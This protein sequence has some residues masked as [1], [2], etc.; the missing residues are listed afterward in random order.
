MALD[1]FNFSIRLNA[2]T[3]N[4]D[5]QIA[6]EQNVSYLRFNLPFIEGLERQLYDLRVRL[7]A[8]TTRHDTVVIIDVD[9]PSLLAEG[10][11]PWPRAKIAQLVDAL[12]NDYGISTMGFDVLFAEPEN[13]Y[14]LDEVKT[15]LANNGATIDT[16]QGISGDARLAQ[17][18][19]DRSIVLGIVFEPGGEDVAQ[20][21]GVLP[22]P[23]FAF[24][25]IPLETILSE[26]RAPLTARYSA[27]IPIL[28]DSAETAG[29]FS[30]SE[31]DSDGI[32]RRVE[33]LT[34]YDG[35]LYGSM[36]LKLI[37]SFFQ[38]LPEPV[39]VGTTDD[40]YPGLEAISM[41]L[42]ENPLGV[43][44]NASV[45]VPYAKRGA[46][47]EYVSATEILQ[48]TYEG[49]LAGTIAILGT[50]SQGLG[51]RRSTPIGPA[52]P[53][54]EIH[55]NIVAGILDET[56][57]FE[58]PWVLAA[59]VLLVL[60]VGI[61]LSILFPYLSALWS[62]ALLV[63]SLGGMVAMN[64]YFWTKENYILA[65]APVL[66]LI[67]LLYVMNTVVG[68]FT[69]AA[70][71][72]TS[73]KMFGLYVPPEVVTKMSA[74]TDI[75]S[76]KSEKREMT[77]LFADIRDFTT[78]S[79]SMSPEDLSDWLNRFLTPMTQIIHKH[80]G[81]IDKYMGDAIMAFWGAPLDD[82]QHAQN[83][84][85]ASHE[86][87]SYLEGYNIELEKQSKPQIH[88]GI[89]L[90]SG[91]MSVGNMGSEFRMAYTV[92]G[93]AV[94]LGSRLEGLTKQCGVTLIVS[95]FTKAYADGYQ[96]QELD[97]VKVKGKT[98]GVTIYSCEPLVS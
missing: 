76:L 72:R 7:S 16:L 5:A 82:D 15:A 18:L 6:S 71:R 66:F 92:V 91:M 48:G 21:V 95:E 63:F 62:T 11:W 34:K 36:S 14:T 37:Q 88:I 53:G 93:D 96:Y 45:Y 70:A 9:E 27:N 84:I 2:N 57:K 38:D 80:G 68:F 41:L 35:Q 77:V 58:P 97:H 39:I 98:K 75:Y 89:G 22:D 55:A 90:N 52:L 29:F 50:S 24:S 73:Q 69:E 4:A 54:V 32:I 81:A 59:N 31:Q 67:L 3:E 64:W 26:T 86:M 47:F 85:N 8:R 74:D 78:I 61:I 28:Q 44:A 1:Q 19:K 12:F 87:L 30:I 79:E 23:M 17:S 51:D 25:E 56:F 49:S 60:V 40:D 43:D 10:Q 94:N 46:G 13:S 20:S 42:L 33:M 83:A 65:L